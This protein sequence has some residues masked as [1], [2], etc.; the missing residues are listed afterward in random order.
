LWSGVWQIPLVAEAVWSEP[1]S[2]QITLLGAI[3][4]EFLR[5]RPA[6]AQTSENYAL[7]IRGLTGFSLDE[8]TAN[9]KWPTANY[10][11]DCSEKFA[12]SRTPEIGLH[13]GFGRPRKDGAATVNGQAGPHKCSPKCY[14]WNKHFH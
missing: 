5:K 2:V 14:H 4:R 11:F 7:K 13:A 6:E 8:G 12:A 9:L 1:V 10:L 3:I